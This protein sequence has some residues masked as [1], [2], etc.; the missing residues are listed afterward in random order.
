MAFWVVSLAT[1]MTYGRLP[2]ASLLSQFNQRLQTKSLPYIQ[3]AVRFL[4]VILENITVI[5]YVASVASIAVFFA[6]SAI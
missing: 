3:I 2:Q 1:H 4:R 5:S 6:A